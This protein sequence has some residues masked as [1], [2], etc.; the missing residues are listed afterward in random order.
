M[1]R[2]CWYIVEQIRHHVISSSSKSS[3][4]D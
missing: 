1:Y 2:W 4:C 3:E